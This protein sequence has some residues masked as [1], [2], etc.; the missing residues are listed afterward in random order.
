MVNGVCGGEV[1]VIRLNTLIS[2]LNKL[3]VLPSERN[4]RH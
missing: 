3:D 1:S 2:N 4:A